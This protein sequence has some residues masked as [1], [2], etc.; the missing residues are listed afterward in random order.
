MQ[1]DALIRC[2]DWIEAALSYSDH[3]HTF[4]DIA[5]GILS[6]RFR[7]WEK[8]RGC[9]VTE[10]IVYPRKKV[11]NVFLAGGDMQVIKD[12]QEP[13]SEFA[14]MNG[15]SELVL[16]GRKGWVRALEKNGWVESHVSMK[17]AL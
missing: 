7:L 9:A 10:F 5:A 2:R 15:C 16:T 1:F 13:C 11:C 12:L 4:D 8:P 6:G 3:T 17:R 14:R